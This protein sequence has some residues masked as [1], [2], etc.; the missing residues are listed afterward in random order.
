MI[1]YSTFAEIKEWVYHR[2]VQIIPIVFINIIEAFENID[3][4]ISKNTDLLILLIYSRIA[5]V[6]ESH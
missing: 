3:H 6:K 2:I 1:Y 4:A 5:N